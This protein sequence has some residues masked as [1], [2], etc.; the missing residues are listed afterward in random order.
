MAARCSGARSTSHCGIVWRRR[1]L[2][3]AVVDEAAHG[4]ETGVRSNRVCVLVLTAPVGK[5]MWRLRV[6]CP[7]EFS[8]GAPR[9]D[10]NRWQ[11]RAQRIF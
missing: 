7:R 3:S 6:R 2:S 8:A 1:R 10:A 4:S 11:L 9:R 5:V